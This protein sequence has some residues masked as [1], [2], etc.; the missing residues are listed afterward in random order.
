[1]RKN[2]LT[3][4]LSATPL[5]TMA[6]TPLVLTQSNY[7]VPANAQQPSQEASPAGVALP[8]RGANRSWNYGSLTPRSGS[9]PST[10][11]YTAGT[12]AALPGSSRYYT[13][14]IS[15]GSAFT[16]MSNQYEALDATGHYKV[17]FEVPRQ[18]YSIGS[19][20]FNPNDS[21]SFARQTQAYAA[22][23]ANLVFPATYNQRFTNAFYRTTTNY[24]LKVAA[25]GLNNVPGQYVQ[26]V[27]PVADS[28]VGWGTLRIPTASG[29]S[30]PVRV[31]L[32]RQQSMQVDS[33]Y[34]GG[35]PA[36]TP[37]LA[38]FGFTQGQISEG[39]AWRFYR[40]NSSQ[41]VLTI[42]QSPSSGQINGVVY[43]LEANIGLGTRAA[44]AGRLAHLAVA[45][46][47]LADELRLQADGLPGEVLQAELRDLSGR[48]VAAGTL[49]IGQP[50]PLTRGL[51]PGLYLLHLTSTRNEQTVL[52]VV[53]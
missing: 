33:I 45:P 47:P 30:N 24:R 12:N 7:L 18:Q 26:R 1:M 34:L 5:L 38:A 2:L 46:Q 29:A 32:V 51:A 17:G 44:Q 11:Q 28:V 40:E 6:Q 4:L 43:S 39:I 3:V 15:F 14:R 41:P 27:T 8:L 21:I 52:Q 42:Y 25:F 23:S 16:L 37:L 9:S 49:T 13:A 35:A 31:L 50:S 10:L 36:P 53:R 20:T 19:A 22:R 48:S